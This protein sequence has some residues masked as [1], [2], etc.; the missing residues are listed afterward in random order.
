MQ[1]MSSKSRPV[2]GVPACLID[3][4][5]H[6]FHRVSDKYIQAV[7]NG[8]GCTP[9]LIPALGDWLDF[10]DIVDRLAGLFLP[11]SPS[12]VAPHPYRGTPRREGP[13]PHPLR[14]APPPPLLL[15]PMPT[16]PAPFH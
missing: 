6:R 10:G 7:V 4:G 16:R 11:R 5:E 14:A 2:V 13:A 9:L 1:S 12:T 3:D 8:T 15:S